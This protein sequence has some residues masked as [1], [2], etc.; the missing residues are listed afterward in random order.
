MGVG[1]ARWKGKEEVESW[2]GNCLYG[3]VALFTIPPLYLP[4]VCGIYA[5]GFNRMRHVVKGRF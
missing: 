5:H 1:D 4:F 2:L 3:C